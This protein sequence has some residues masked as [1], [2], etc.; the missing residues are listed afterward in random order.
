MLL[1]HVNGVVAFVR[2]YLC[3]FDCYAAEYAE[4]DVLSPFLKHK[5][6]LICNSVISSIVV[7]RT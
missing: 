3:L 7:S 1:Q 4:P 2:E 6:C 5:G